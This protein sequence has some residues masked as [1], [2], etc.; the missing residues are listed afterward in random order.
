M[1]Q[2]LHKSV[3]TE[4]HGYPSPPCMLLSSGNVM[5][6][7]SPNTSILKENQVLSQRNN[8]CDGT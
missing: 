8:G 3:E 7:A 4:S 6:Y 5:G 1:G 2:R